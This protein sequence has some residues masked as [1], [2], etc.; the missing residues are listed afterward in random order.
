[1][2]ANRKPYAPLDFDDED[3][4]FRGEDVGDDDSSHPVRPYRQP[5]PSQH[6]KGRRRVW[7]TVRRRIGA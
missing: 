4:M 3:A 2:A 5:S 1:M 7:G 6:P